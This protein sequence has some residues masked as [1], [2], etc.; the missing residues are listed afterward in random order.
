M[1]AFSSRVLLAVCRLCWGLIVLVQRGA[2]A[3][4]RSAL[5]HTPLR[6]GSMMQCCVV[7]VVTFHMRVC[8]KALHQHLHTL[9]M[10]SAAACISSVLPLFFF[11]QC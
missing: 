10:P 8:L 3:P 11:E 1:I 5:A 4:R 7:V 9:R 2:F 6:A